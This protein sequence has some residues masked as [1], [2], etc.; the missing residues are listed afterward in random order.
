M[1]KWLDDVLRG[2][3]VEQYSEAIVETLTQ[4][5]ISKNLIS[6][7]ETKE[8][9]KN[10]FTKILESIVERDKAE[11]KKKFEELIGRRIDDLK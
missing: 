8:Y 7:D 2:Y 9:F 11:A 3:S 1:D 5:L 4:L 6:T 10:N